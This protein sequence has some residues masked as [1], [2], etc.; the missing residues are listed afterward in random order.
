MADNP[1]ADKA[2]TELRKQQQ[3]ADGKKAMLDYE[4]EAA[5]VRARTEKLRALRLARDAAAPPAQPKPLVRKRSAQTANAAAGRSAGT[6]AGR[7]KAKPKAQP[8]SD[9]LDQQKKDGRRD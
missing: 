9:W 1:K 3:A 8:L 5:A 4:A 6:A 2:S 7:A